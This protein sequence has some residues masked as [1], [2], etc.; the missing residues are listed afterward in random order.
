M[1]MWAWL[2][3]LRWPRKFGVQMLA[4]RVVACWLDWLV[5][6][7]VDCWLARCLLARLLALSVGLCFVVSCQDLQRL[8]ERFSARFGGKDMIVLDLKQA[9][10]A[11]DAHGPTPQVGDGSPKKYPK[12]FPG[13]EWLRLTQDSGSD[14]P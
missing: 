13:R 3:A 14:G 6:S 11:M 12:L 1:S 7:C 8:E 10:E 9:V 2:A 5:A 4:G